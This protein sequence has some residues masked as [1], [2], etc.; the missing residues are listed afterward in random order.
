M[1]PL[2]RILVVMPN[3]YGET[4][5]T[6][7]LLR[8]L[9]RQRPEAWVAAL[10]LRRAGEILVHNPD[11]N[12][13]IEFA[14]PKGLD[15]VFGCRPLIARLRG[16]R[17]D[18]A[19]LLR[20][21]F[22]RALLLARAGIPVRVGFAHPK[23]AWLLT[24][25]APLP[26]R[27][28]HKALEYLP[29]LSAAGLHAEEGAF[30]YVVSDVEREGA[31]QR[32]AQ[33]GLADRPFAV[34]HPGA[35]WAHKRWPA[36]RF[37]ALADRLA[38][39]GTPVLIT[40]GPDDAALLN[41]VQ[42]RMR[43]TAASTAGTATLRQTAACFERAA[44][45]ITNDTGM[46]HVAAALGRPL[47]ALFGPTSPAYTGPIGEPS[48]TRVLHHSGCCPAIPCLKPEALP[49]HPGMM[50]ISVEEAYTA[51]QELLPGFNATIRE[52]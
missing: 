10:G 49:P 28:R 24:H 18:A 23:S 44:L 42:G 13:F 4:L 46:A 36:D 50:S 19:F 27:Q 52:P 8:A 43:Q 9:R 32:L 5:F 22:S 7:P 3:W 2:N 29:L 45:V 14:E 33:L 48:R 25:R 34:V 47:L 51:A 17:F 38:A 31:R 39:S 16:E 26:P 21:S 41:A 11:V 37:A 40:G 30:R 20:P 1:Q 35:N 15:A 12:A 6:T